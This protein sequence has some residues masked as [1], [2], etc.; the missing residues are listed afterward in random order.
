MLPAGHTSDLG[1]K[2][3]SLINF[4]ETGVILKNKNKNKNHETEEE[5][6]P[7][8]MRVSRNSVAELDQR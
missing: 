8:E 2:E 7:L 6:E 1:L 5:D 3:L 4:Q